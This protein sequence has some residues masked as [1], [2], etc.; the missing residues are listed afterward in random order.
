M[1]VGANGAGDDR[2]DDGLAVVR[3]VAWEVWKAQPGGP[4]VRIEAAD[5]RARDALQRW[6][7]VH[8]G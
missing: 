7:L 3:A 2:D 6:S 4:P 1:T 5:G 8:G